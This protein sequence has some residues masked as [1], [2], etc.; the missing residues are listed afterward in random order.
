MIKDPPLSLSMY[1]ISHALT[2]QG[3]LLFVDV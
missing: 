2:N 1:G 3:P